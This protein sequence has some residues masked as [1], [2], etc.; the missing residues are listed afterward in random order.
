MVLLLER[1]Q[2]A[3]SSQSL[4]EQDLGAIQNVLNKVNGAINEVL[5]ESN[6]EIKEIRDKIERAEDNIISEVITLKEMIKTLQLATKDSDD[7]SLD[8]QLNEIEQQR[9]IWISRLELAQKKLLEIIPRIEKD[10][11]ATTEL[12]KNSKGD[13]VTSQKLREARYEEFNFRLHEL[14]WLGLIARKR[15]QT[16]WHY[17]RTD[18]GSKLI[19]SK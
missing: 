1:V 6:D 4:S 13:Q 5:E 3:C 15:K 14:R 19:S 9:D 10:A 17:W 7:P 11:C 18:D 8:E 16:D 2:D 12:F